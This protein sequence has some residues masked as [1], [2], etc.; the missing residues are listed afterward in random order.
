[1][2]PT[3]EAGQFVLIDEKRTPATGE[4]AVA[5]HPTEVD[6]LV[7]KRV[8][9]IS[10]D[11]EFHLVSDNVDAGTDS[12]AWGLIPHSEIVGTVTLV[13]DN[14]GMDLSA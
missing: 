9:E 5:N 3:L 6:L 4:L 7:I 1:M 2:L 11:H 14:P 8:G 13:L 10:P 12:R